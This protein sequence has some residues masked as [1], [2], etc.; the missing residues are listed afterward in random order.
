MDERSNS[1]AVRF[2]FKSFSGTI[3]FV[4][5]LEEHWMKNKYG[6]SS[7]RLFNL[8]LQGGRLI[9]APVMRLC[10]ENHVPSIIQPREV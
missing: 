7:P 9:G 5:S 10:V 1:H 4:R 8:S 6:L 2:C 3:S